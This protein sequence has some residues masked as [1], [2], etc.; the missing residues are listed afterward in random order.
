ML[1]ERVQ[2]IG[3][4]AT[5]RINAI[6]Q[7]LRAAG[8]DVL[9]LSAGQPDF[10]TPESVKAAGVAAIEA[11]H[12]RYTANNGLLELREAIAGH[13]GRGQGLDIA[14]D[15]VLVSAG[16]KASLYFASMALLDPGD[17]VLIPV[18]YWVSY[19]EQVGLAQGVP[20]FVEAGED[21]GFKLDVDAL[22]AAR[23]ART[24]LLILNY[25]SNPTGASYEADE[26]K[27]IGEF[28]AQHDIW[29]LADEIYGRLLYDG[30]RFH[31]I[32]QSGDEVRAKTIVVNGMSKTYAMTGWR[33]GY[34]AGPREV[35]SGMAKIQS[36]STSNATSIS[37]WASIEALRVSEAELDRRVAE[38][39]QRR[40]EIVAG[41]R[42]IPGVDCVM[43]QGAFYV[44]PNVSGCFGGRAGLTSGEGVAAR[45][46]EQAKVAVVPGE[47]FGN[48]NHIRISYA[49]SIERVREGVE[50]IA[51][52]LAD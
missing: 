17:E 39:Q 33:I 13:L 49:C 40:D 37:Q 41:L 18:P 28:C 3:M 35:I 48:P 22:E 45:L 31:G 5:L 26:L 51:R 36:H 29:I 20:V 30:R 50:R 16:A 10:P 38:F 11:N 6:A 8:E 19:P 32:A 25:P 9:D 1:A 44:F 24:K 21:A 23:S 42:A 4:S 15:Q 34:A 46:L 12:T 52:A 27:R 14:A 47:A 2:R 7:E 43:P